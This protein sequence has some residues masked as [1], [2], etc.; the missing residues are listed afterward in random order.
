MAG[1]TK[2]IMD[3]AGIAKPML[4]KII[5]LPLL[6]KLRNKV[7]EAHLRRLK[8]E[9]HPYEAGH[10]KK[11]VNLIGS[12]RQESGL[13]QS[14]RLAASALKKAEIPFTVYDYQTSRTAYPADHSL[15]QNISGDTCYDINLIH[16][17]PAELGTA[18]CKL[19]KSLW[20]YRYNIAFWL[21]SRKNSRRNGRRIF[22]AWMKSGR[23]QSLFVRQSAKK[24]RCR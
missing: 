3:T 1:I 22:N 23:R 14:C 7:S 17:N 13:G 18:Y 15:E 9:I 6:W 5:P 24:Q 20:D 11:G 8:A 12:I 19:D 4:K 10:Y 21:W 16:I 2:I